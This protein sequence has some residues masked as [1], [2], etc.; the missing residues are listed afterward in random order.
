MLQSIDQQFI[1]EAKEGGRR[2]QAAPPNH[3]VTK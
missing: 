3:T 1:D 2:V